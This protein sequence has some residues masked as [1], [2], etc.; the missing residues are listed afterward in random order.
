MNFIVDFNLLE[1]VFW[2][3]FLNGDETGRCPSKQQSLGLRI[4]GD[5]MILEA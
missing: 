4:T 5:G 2:E 3:A 1:T